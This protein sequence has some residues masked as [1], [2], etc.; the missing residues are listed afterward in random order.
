MV[1]ALMCAAG[2]EQLAQASGM[3]RA[4]AMVNVA[5]RMAA[6]FTRVFAER[7]QRPSLRLTELFSGKH[8]FEQA[9]EMMV[10][11][12]NHRPNA[13]LPHTFYLPPPNHA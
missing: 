9:S 13:Y 5:V 8:S 4:E 11:G 1:A 7:Q 2:G 3:V 6:R 10:D 12:W